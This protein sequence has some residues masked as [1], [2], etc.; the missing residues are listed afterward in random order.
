MRV[1]LHAMN[2]NRFHPVIHEGELGDT[3]V[4]MVV[5]EQEIRETIAR[6]TSNGTR[7][8]QLRKEILELMVAFEC[9][10]KANGEFHDRLHHCHDLAACHHPLHSK[11]AD[12]KKLDGLMTRAKQ[13]IQ[14]KLDGMTGVFVSKKV[15]REI[16]DLLITLVAEASFYLGTAPRRH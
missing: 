1:E 15:E 11:L 8:A 5:A 4:E 9:L 3:T 10:K 16:D 13:E 14:R 6:L 2:Q 12:L 7:G